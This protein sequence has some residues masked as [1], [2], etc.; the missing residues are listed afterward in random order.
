MR[1]REW[2]FLL[3]LAGAGIALANFVGFKVGFMES[4]PGIAILLVV[5]LCAAFL[6]LPFAN[7]CLLL[8]LRFINSFTYISN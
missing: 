7:S 4:L 2:I 3:L 1:Y 6:S 8:N 5:S